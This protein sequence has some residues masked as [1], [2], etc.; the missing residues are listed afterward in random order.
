MR[1]D[2]FLASLNDL[3]RGDLADLAGT[4]G[5]VVVAPHPDDESLG[6]G[7]L[8]ARAC[9]EGRSVRLVVV[10]DGCG[11]HT[12]SRTHPPER[13]RALREAETL[14]AVA[15]L[16]LAA[17]HVRFLRL[18]DAAVPCEGEGGQAAAEAVARA[19]R[20]CAAGAI[21]VTW[22]HDPHCDHAASA[23]IVDL[24]RAAL[25]DIR[26]FHYPVW[27]WRLPPETEVGPRPEGLRLDVGAHSAAKRRAVM[28]HASQ[29][30]DLI[31]DD[32]TGF[33]LERSMIDRLCGPEEV[34]IEVPR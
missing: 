21:M 20:D 6:C 16:G 1:A 30:T 25:G 12:H 14:A 17:D 15:E 27:G 3:P 26:V 9:G 24:A 22:R 19:A 5:L 18:P 10:S 31:A 32:P 28:A 2:A 8:I 23:A 29:T 13:L 4:G 11:S 34:Y 33:R 7:G